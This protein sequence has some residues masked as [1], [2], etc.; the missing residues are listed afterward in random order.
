MSFTRFS[1]ERDFLL[2]FTF[3]SSKIDYENYLK[4]H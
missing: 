1:Y 4:K 3:N 2:N